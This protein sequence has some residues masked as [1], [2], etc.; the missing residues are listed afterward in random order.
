MTE[1]AGLMKFDRGP[2]LA[3]GPD[4]GHAWFSA[5]VNDTKYLAKQEMIIVA[6]KATTQPE[7]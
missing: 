3:R 5:L 2:H 7:S 6:S 1:A 4:F